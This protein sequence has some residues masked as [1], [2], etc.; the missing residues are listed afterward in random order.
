M[1]TQPNTRLT[2][3]YPEPKSFEEVAANNKVL[4]F[5]AQNFVVNQII[6]GEHIYC[7]SQFEGYPPQ[8][9]AANPNGP[10]SGIVTINSTGETL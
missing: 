7:S 9:Q 4:M 1:T 10:F 3:P 5:W 6:S 2:F 8:G